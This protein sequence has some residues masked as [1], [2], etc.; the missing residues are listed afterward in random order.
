MRTDATYPCDALQQAWHTVL[1]HLLERPLARPRATLT[2]DADALALELR[3]FQ[4][5]TLRFAR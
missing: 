2:A 4:L 3:P 1:L 5:A